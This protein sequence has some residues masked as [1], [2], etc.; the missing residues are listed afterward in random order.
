MDMER[1]RVGL[2]TPPLLKPG[3]LLCVVLP[4]GSGSLKSLQAGIE[5]WRDW[6][7]DVIP[8]LPNTPSG[9]DYLAGSDGERLRCLQTAFD[10]PSYRAILCGRGGYGATR[11]LP[12]LDW[13]GFLDSPKWIV[14]F[15]DITALLWAAAARGVASIHGPIVAHMPLESVSSRDRLHRLLSVGTLEPLQGESWSAGSATGILMPAN[16]TVAAAM[17]G[18][19]DWPLGERCLER[20][21]IILAIEEINEQ[22][23]RIDRLLTQWRNAGVFCSVAGVALGR[24]CWTDAWT[25]EKPYSVEV[26]LQDRLLDLGIPVVAGLEFGHGDGDNLALPVG[27]EAAIDGDK[28]TLAI[29]K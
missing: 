29:L 4:S 20:R 2:E 11:L 19:P 10:D 3:D 22:D 16:L 28:G 5:L 17:L 26:T 15:S 9:L 8:L 27:V 1:M 25:E 7:Y 13:A 12:Q 18:T 6:G 24:F 23:Y 21:K 14:G